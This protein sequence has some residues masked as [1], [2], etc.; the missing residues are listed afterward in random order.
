MQRYPHIDIAKG[1][2]IILVV[3]GHIST[4]NDLDHKYIFWFH[5]PAFFILSGLFLA[6]ERPMRDEAK[7][8]F[9]R[10]I[11]P[12]LVFSLTLGTLARGGDIIKQTVGTLISANGNITY[13]TYPYY[14]IVVLFGAT[15]IYCAMRRYLPQDDKRVRRTVVIVGLC[16]IATHL[17]AS[18][19]PDGKL[20]W[21]PW[22]IDMML[23][24]LSYLFLGDRFREHILNKD[25]QA[26]KFIHRGGWIL[27]AVILIVSDAIGVFDYTF[28][29][30]SHNWTWVAD[31]VFPIVFTL[32]TLQVSILAERVSFLKTTLSHIGKISL[33]ILLLHA[34]YIGLG[35]AILP[36]WCGTGSLLVFDIALCVLSHFILSKFRLGKAV[37]GENLH[38]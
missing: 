35:K 33:V 5:M 4:G 16:Y 13:Y 32:A 30:K 1:L 23:F 21:I 34:A 10:L 6:K 18:F 19:V 2:L 14:F 25:S 22:N 24:A 37:M 26:V 3:L 9:R 38:S 11:V 20:G 8:R 15:L 27:T 29:F 17:L 12:Y 7:N 36:K 28:D 31:I